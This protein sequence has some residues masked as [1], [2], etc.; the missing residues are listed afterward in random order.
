MYSLWY[1]P[2]NQ[3][4]ILGLLNTYHHLPWG[5]DCFEATGSEQ[6]RPGGFLTLGCPPAQ[7]RTCSRIWAVWSSG[8]SKYSSPSSASELSA[9]SVF[10]GL[11]LRTY[12]RI[13][14]TWGF[15]GGSVI[16]NPPANAETRV[17]SLGREDSLEKEV[18]TQSSTLAW[19]VPWTEEPGGPQSMGSQEQDTT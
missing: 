9:N 11:L 3:V 10:T 16:K 14:E 5:T 2:W 7:E 18:A 8:N 13:K 6:H 17:R 19:E 12:L 4:S 15:P 1:H